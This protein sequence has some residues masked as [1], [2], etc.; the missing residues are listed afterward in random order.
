MRSMVEGAPRPQS[1]RRTRSTTPVRAA[2][3]LPVSRG[4]I[5][6]IRFPAQITR[7]TTSTSSAAQS[8]QLG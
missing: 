6:L 7:P 3:L 8:G 4:R 1:V 2:A 5:Y